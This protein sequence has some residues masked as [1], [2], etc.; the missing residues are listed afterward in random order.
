[1]N[2]KQKIGMGVFFLLFLSAQVFATKSKHETDWYLAKK[3]NNISLFYR[4]IQLE[5]G[6]QTREMKAEF[7]IEAGISEILSQFLTTEKYL[8]WAA[9]IKKCGIEK[10]HDTLWYTHTI[11]NYPWPFKQKDLVTKHTI[12]QSKNKTSIEIEAVPEFMAEIIGIERMKNYRGTWHLYQNSNGS[13]SV[14]YRMVSFEK[15]VFPRFVQD[16]VIQKI[17]MNSF[18]ELKQLAEAE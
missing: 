4:W 3:S 17:T 5:N 11:M 16:P 7:E 9:G 15:P 18:V 1:M 10:Y 13:T 8:K 6:N 12:R 2:R 14:D